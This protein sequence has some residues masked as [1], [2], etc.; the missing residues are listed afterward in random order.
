LKEETVDQETAE[1]TVGTTLR[2]CYHPLVGYQY[3]PQ[4]QILPRPD[5]GTYELRVNAAGIRSDREHTLEKPDGVYRILVF[6]CSQSE[7]HYQSNARRFSEILERR[8]PGLEILNFSLPGAGTDQHLLVYEEI[9]S[10]YQHDLV[11]VMPF[12]E[13]I[14]RIMA[15]NVASREPATGRITYWPKPWFELITQ[16]DESE[17][18]KLHNVPVPRDPVESAR[19]DS[20][21]RRSGLRERAKKILFLRRL[22]RTLGPLLSH[23]GYDP[24]PEYRSADTREWRLMS[25]VIRRFGRRNDRPVVI[26]PLVDSW[27]M[28][29]PRGQG[30][31]HRFDSLADGKNVHVID[32]LPYFLKLGRKLGSC[33]MEPDPHFSDFGQEV[34]ADAVEGELRR[35][36][37][38]R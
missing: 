1:A 16:S 36:G 19:P 18:L 29:F 11:L 33:F 15:Q 3:E 23:L 31:W 12:L 34:L 6:G 30:Y 7:G 14:R 8:H 28:R 27:Y 13:N 32:V 5:G 22:V 24:Y 38:L 2:M 4:R 37:V 20:V 10:K 35:L 17:D 9:G 26:A 21:N 25:A